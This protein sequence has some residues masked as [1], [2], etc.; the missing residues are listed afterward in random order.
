MSSISPKPVSD[1]MRKEQAGDG[2]VVV[3]V[4]NCGGAADCSV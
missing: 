2:I 4:V 1:M 3:V